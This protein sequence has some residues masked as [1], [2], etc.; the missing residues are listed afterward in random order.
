ML[1]GECAGGGEDGDVVQETALARRH[2]VGACSCSEEGERESAERRGHKG[3]QK[4]KDKRRGGEER[5]LDGFVADDGGG[6]RF[7]NGGADS[8]SGGF[9]GG[10]WEGRGFCHIVL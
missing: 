3:C 7:R 8:L 5:T 1:D 6:L 4:G 2:L 9:L 10:W